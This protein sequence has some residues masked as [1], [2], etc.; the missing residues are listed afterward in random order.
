MQIVRIWNPSIHAAVL[1][2]VDGGDAVDLSHAWASFAALADAARR[3][4]VP[5]AALTQAAVKTSSQ[6][7]PFNSLLQ[8]QAHPVVA[9]LLQPVDAGEYWG[10]GVTYERS[11]LAR[12]AESQSADVYAR[13]Y[14]AERPEIFFKATPSRCVGPNQPVGIRADS[15]WSVPEP[16]LALVLDRDGA[17][18]GYTLGNDMSA[19]DIEG[20]N[21]L[22]LPQAKVYQACCAIGP[23]VLLAESGKHPEFEIRCRIIRKGEE[24]FDGSTTTAR[25]RR[26]FDELAAY[27]R[28]HNPLPPVTVLLTGTGIVPPDEFT[29]REGDVVEIDSPL[30]GTLRNPVKVVEAAQAAQ[31]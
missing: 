12:M 28:R 20:D 6:R 19:R 17:I 13:I 21:P 11:R 1:A 15:R 25:M 22:Y 30:L 5:A 23:T 4:G 24:V 3:E 2:A 26:S 18:L 8:A 7:W 27:L 9:H 14:Q 31:G 29:L 16:E 10:A